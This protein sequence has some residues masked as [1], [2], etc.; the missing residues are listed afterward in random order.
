MLNDFLADILDADSEFEKA[1]AQDVLKSQKFNFGEYDNLPH[2]S[3]PEHVFPY[4]EHCPQVFNLPYPNCLFY[5]EG[6]FYLHAKNGTEPG[7]IDVRFICYTENGDEFYIYPI[8]GNIDFIG[9]RVSAEP[10][11][12]SPELEKQKKLELIAMLFTLLATFLTVVNSSNI[13]TVDH[14]P[15]IESQGSR[16]KTEDR[17]LLVYKT[18]HINP[19]S[20]KRSKKSQTDSPVD[21]NKP[22]LRVH[23][24]R[25]HIRRLENSVVW[26]QPSVVGK[27]K[28][29]TVDKQYHVTPATLKD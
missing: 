18:L 11:M 12:G 23:L 10:F 17:K 27:S 20:N 28:Y 25:G 6:G 15:S 14:V 8:V 21:P 16:L 22:G 2:L 7:V 26:V 1:W 24:R 4:V 5:T 29:G 19:L 9:Q 13:S 3:K